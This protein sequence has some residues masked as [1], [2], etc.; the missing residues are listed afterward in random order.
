MAKLVLNDKTVRD[1]EPPERGNR[2]DYDEPK[3]PRDR[4]FVRGFAVR[5]TAAGSK[6]FLLVYVTKDGRER[7]QTIGA[8]GAH[9]VTT[10]REAA[11][12]LRLQVDAGD[13]PFAAQ[14]DRRSTA[15]AKR[16]R[17]GATLGV[18]LEAYVLALKRGRKA[19]AAKV[20]GEIHRTIK[21]PFPALWKKPAGDVT[22]EDLVKITNRLVRS[23][24]WRQAEKTRAYLRSAYTA[25]VAARGSS[26]SADLFAGFEH[27]QNVA[28][29]LATID[30]PGGERTP[31]Q[32]PEKRALSVA[33]L[34][35]YWRRI[36]SMEGP[37]GAALRFHLLTG[38]QR[39]EQ[40]ARLTVADLD[41]DTKTVTL[42]DGKGRRK[43]P[44]A[45]VVPLLPDALAALDAMRGDKGPHLFTL[46][47][48]QHGAGYHTLRGIVLGVAEQMAEAGETSATFTPGELR[49]TVETRLSALKVPRETRAHLQS[50]GL[51]GVQGKHYD[52]HDYLDEK[53]DALRALRRLC[54]PQ[55]AKVSTI[56]GRRK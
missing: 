55:P 47:S 25:C 20:E 35:A 19:S 37:H 45:H 50:H 13:D 12:S 8:F 28:R 18:M 44:R 36:R 40:L 27:V 39:A 38:A 4:E 21:T 43:T 23:G 54:D 9:T 11:R 56:A 42:M 6:A 10:A 41:R 30:R 32:G 5:T 2:I 24:T 51:G 22:L 34:A 1:L 7:R 29:D 26:A 33:E 46:D 15:E 48:G 3:G 14:Q 52:R 53:R 16:D 31:E 17:D 49:I